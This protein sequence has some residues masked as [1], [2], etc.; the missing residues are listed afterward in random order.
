MLLRMTCDENNQLSTWNCTVVIQ[1]LKSG[2]F[3]KGQEG[4]QP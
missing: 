3:R 1:A 4:Q 2:D